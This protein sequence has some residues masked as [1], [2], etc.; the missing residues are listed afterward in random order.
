MKRLGL[1]MVPVFQ[2]TDVAVPETLATGHIIFGFAVRL[3]ST[4]RFA[5]TNINVVLSKAHSKTMLAPTGKSG[6]FAEFCLGW[7]MDSRLTGRRGSITEFGP[8]TLG[9]ELP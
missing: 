2:T 4:V 9:P 5:G 3:T 6:G 8:I 7:V 1:V